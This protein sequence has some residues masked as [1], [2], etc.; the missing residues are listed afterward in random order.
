MPMPGM[1]IN[2][3]SYTDTE[4][5]PMPRPQSGDFVNEKTRLK[6][7]KA[8]IAELKK[9]LPKLKFREYDQG[10]CIFI[11]LRN[12][13]QAIR[14]QLNTLLD[15]LDPEKKFFSSIYSGF[16]RS[17]EARHVIFVSNTRTNCANAL[18]RGDSVSLTQ[19]GTNHHNELFNQE[20]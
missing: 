16:L 11:G 15:N 8:L 19:Q 10:L 14:Q 17:T 3:A 6:S 20:F 4:T 1:P 13:N 2:T 18:H 7:R 5:V 12:D 9:Y